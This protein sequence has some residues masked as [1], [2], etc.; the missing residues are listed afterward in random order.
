MSLRTLEQHAVAHGAQDIK[1]MT[2]ATMQLEAVNN[3][4]A[5]K[6]A[7]HCRHII[8]TSPAAARF[9]SLSPAF[10]INEN[11]HWFTP[12]QG[13]ANALHKLGIRQIT[14]P[15]NASD[16]ENLLALPALQNLQ[17]QSVGLITAPGGRGLIEPTLVKR[18]IKVHMANVYQRKT[19]ALDAEKIQALRD[20]K[21]P[22]AVLCSSN[23]VFQSLWKQSDASLREKLKLGLW[24]VSS[25]RLQ[26][27]LL[28]S[29]ISNSSVS[30]SAQ[31]K[32]MLDHFIHVRTQQ[33]R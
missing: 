27:L 16:S 23:E 1:F 32:A 28:E 5:L 12:G 24:I 15:E 10:F 3:D 14:F 13:T 26:D 30:H 31:P 20:L 7:L 6:N 11:A 29:G 22:F 18:G 9:A 21:L 19:I 8:V 17:N 4:A 2:C 25:A 33:L